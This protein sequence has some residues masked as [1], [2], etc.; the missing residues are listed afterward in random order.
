MNECR[1][2]VRDMRGSA[3]RRPVRRVPDSLSV[4]DSEMCREMRLACRDVPRC[5]ETYTH[6][7][8]GGRWNIGNVRDSPHV[9]EI[10]P[11]CRDS[12]RVPRFALQ[13]HRVMTNLPT[14]FSPPLKTP[15]FFKTLIDIPAAAS[16]TIEIRL[17]EVR[18]RCSA[19]ALQPTA[20]RCSPLHPLLLRPTLQALP[21]PLPLALPIP[22]ALSPTRCAVRSP[23]WTTAW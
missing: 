12:R 5:A 10:R 7:E 22:Q 17:E 2:S 14:F 9:P 20:A 11:A 1:V 19:P 4:E 3:P 15:S 18:R 16:A 13:R 23:R 21:L 6:I 8:F